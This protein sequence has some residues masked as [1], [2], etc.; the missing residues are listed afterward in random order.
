MTLKTKASSLSWSN[1]QMDRE[2]PSIIFLRAYGSQ[3]LY[4]PHQLMHCK[5]SLHH[6]HWQEFSPQLHKT[7]VFCP[8]C[9]QGSMRSKV[10]PARYRSKPGVIRSARDPGYRCSAVLKPDICDE[11][12]RNISPTPLGCHP[13]SLWYLRI[14]YSPRCPYFIATSFLNFVYF[15]F[16]YRLLKTNIIESNL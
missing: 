7:D 6:H 8:D 2:M 5:V 10:T 16:I 14:K 12:T 9:K 4:S 1:L 11:V 15:R 13:S 3:Q